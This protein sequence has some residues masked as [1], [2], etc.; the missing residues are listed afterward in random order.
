[1]NIINNLFGNMNIFRRKNKITAND[2]YDLM[3]SVGAAGQSNDVFMHSWR[4]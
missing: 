2:K 3:H 4:N 1:M